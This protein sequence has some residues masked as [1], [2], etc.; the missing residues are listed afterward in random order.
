M[1]HRPGERVGSKVVVRTISTQGCAVEGASGHELGKKC[2]LYIDWH[3]L[4]IGVEAEVASLEPDGLLGLKFLSVDEDMK[5][6]LSELCDELRSRAMSVGV[7]KQQDTADSLAG[8]VS[9]GAKAT[10]IPAPSTPAKPVRERERRKVPRYVSELSAHLS[11]PST[12]TSADV[13]LITL[14]V[15][16]GCLEGAE[17]PVGQPCEISTEWQGKRL[18][19]QADVVWNSEE[20]RV[21]VKFSYL[22]EDAQQLLRQVCSTLRIQPMGPPPKA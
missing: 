5:A 17:F 20:N 10:P 14:S 18:K 22:D 13:A 6:R 8:S 21:G 1:L 11:S 19:L 3:D 16:G 9:T 7:S 2:E 15:L 12:G 4:H